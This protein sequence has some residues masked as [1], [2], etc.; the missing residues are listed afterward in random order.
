MPP[1]SIRPVECSNRA[2]TWSVRNH[3]R[4][5]RNRLAFFATS[6][7]SFDLRNL[8][9]LGVRLG[10]KGAFPLA[11]AVAALLT[12]RRASWL[13]RDE[14]MSLVACW[15]TSLIGGV[16]TCCRNG[17]E[18]NYF[19]E[20]WAVVGFLAVTL[21]RLMIGASEPSAWRLPRPATLILAAV[22]LCSAGAD[23]ACLMGVDRFGTARLSMT[24]GQRVELEKARALTVRAD[25]AV[26]C[27]PA[28][29]GLAWDLPFPAYV[30]DDYP[31]FH[32]PAQK[33]GLLRGSGL[34]GLI[35][36]HHF[37]VLI[38]QLDDTLLF[39]DAINS[40]YVRQ[41]KWSRFAV[42]TD[43]RFAMAEHARDPEIVTGD[44]ASIASDLARKRF[45]AGN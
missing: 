5:P 32:T 27:Q 13:G 24:A 36:D 25:G 2:G 11:C 20:L 12:L 40:G 38:L 17:S 9:H 23:A 34:S 30:F 41:P 31:Y 45:G 1:T 21:A 39:N 29:T 10:L 44:T 42:F 22:A 4:F 33:R 26:F 3:W 37:Q 16:V 28:L 7:S 14:R 8:V 18:L 43:P 15:W 19:F 6:L 35:A